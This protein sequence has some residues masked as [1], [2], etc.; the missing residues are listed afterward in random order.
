VLGEL[1]LRHGRASTQRPVQHWLARKTLV[2]CR[3]RSSH[4]TE[5]DSV[6]LALA[7]GPNVPRPVALALAPG[8]DAIELSFDD[9]SLSFIDRQT[10][11]FAFSGSPLGRRS[12]AQ[13]RDGVST[14]SARTWELTCCS[15]ASLP[16]VA[17]WRDHERLP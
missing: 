10:S 16:S 1:L 13:Q 6:P 2:A 11:E 15:R 12:F 9:G 3:V 4:C 14:V 17:R 8:E 7:A 5:L